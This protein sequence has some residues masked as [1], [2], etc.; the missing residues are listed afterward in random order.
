M[1]LNKTHIALAIVLLMVE[2]VIALFIDDAFVRPYLGDTIATILVF[3]LLMAVFKISVKQGAITALLI[4][5]FIEFTQY[6]KV[7]ELL[8]WENNEL[9]VTLMGSRFSWPDIVAYTAGTAL[10]LGVNHFFL[11][12]KTSA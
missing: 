6:F 5:Y 9:A 2:I 7:I 10:I 3:A 8:G 4:S 12:R 1:R 11:K